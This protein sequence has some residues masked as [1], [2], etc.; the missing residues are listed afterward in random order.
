MPAGKP[1]GETIVVC[2]DPYHVIAITFVNG[3]NVP[4]RPLSLAV[5]GFQPAGEAG[6]PAR[7]SLA[8]AAALRYLAAS[9]VGTRSPQF[10]GK[11]GETGVAG[12]NYSQLQRSGLGGAGTSI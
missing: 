8:Q 3:C 10:R 1:Q 2:F 6:E 12:R 7:R 11:P 4:L 9:L 5:A